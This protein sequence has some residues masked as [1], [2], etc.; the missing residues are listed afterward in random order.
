MP[1]N[2]ESTIKECHDCGQ[3]GKKRRK[4]LTF[5]ETAVKLCFSYSGADWCSIN[6]G[7]LLCDECCSVH[8]GLGRHISQIKSFKRSYWPP[9]Q[10]NVCCSPR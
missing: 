4:T 10:L 3:T 5:L 1:K 8:L 6:H 7:V 2:N 9:T